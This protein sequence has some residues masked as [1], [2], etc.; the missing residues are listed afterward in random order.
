MFNAKVQALNVGVSLKNQCLHM[1]I[2]I[3]KISVSVL[4]MY[5]P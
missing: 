5:L 2:R 1:P 3:M 4:K